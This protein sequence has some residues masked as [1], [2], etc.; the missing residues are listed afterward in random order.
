MPS[1]DPSWSTPAK[2]DGL[3]V[4]HWKR[5]TGYT[6]CGS[7]AQM[8]ERWL[9]LA[10]NQ[11]QE[12]TLGWGPDADGQ[13]GHMS[14]GAI[15]AFVL[16]VGLPPQM[17]ASRAKPPTREEIERMFARPAYRAVPSDGPRQ[18]FNPGPHGKP[19]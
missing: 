8:V 18:H 3:P 13:H 5:R 9:R 16:R 2:L 1:Y 11:Q 6:E 19:Q 10:W 15:A 7:L 12:C 17:L 4:R 14:A